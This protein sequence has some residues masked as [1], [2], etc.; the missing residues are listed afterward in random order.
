M[1]KGIKQCQITSAPFTCFGCFP[2]LLPISTLD[3]STSPLL[4]VLGPSF[5]A[6]SSFSFFFSHTHTP[7]FLAPLLAPCLNPGQPP[8]L[9]QCDHPIVS[10]SLHHPCYHALAA[11]SSLPHLRCPTLVASSSQTSLQ[12]PYP[13]CT[14]LP[15]LGIST[16]ITLL[17]LINRLCRCSYVL[18]SGRAALKNHRGG[19]R[20]PTPLAIFAGD[21]E[22]TTDRMVE[23]CLYSRTYFDHIS[24]KKSHSRK[25]PRAMVKSKSLHQYSIP[26]IH[27]QNYLLIA[28]SAVHIA[29][30]NFM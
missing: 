18:T 8:P 7:L 24:R 29:N 17:A 1:S 30:M 23:R 27:Y 21:H 2:S 11:S 19:C 16:P 26:K 22:S 12:L 25:I 20:T 5:S 28:H 3:I 6:S 15:Q 14:I 4:F 10:H 13:P 9:L